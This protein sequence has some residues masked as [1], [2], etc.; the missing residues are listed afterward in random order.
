MVTYFRYRW[1]EGKV[2]LPVVLLRTKPTTNRA[3]T[4]KVN[5]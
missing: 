5:D 4:G 2:V 3:R 1:V